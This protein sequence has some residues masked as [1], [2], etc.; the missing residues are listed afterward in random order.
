MSHVDPRPTRPGVW[1]AALLVLLFATPSFA[2]NEVVPL[3][4]IPASPCTT[5]DV[6]LVFTICT[7]NSHF[8]SAARVS[9]V[10]ARVDVATDPTVVCVQCAPDTVGVDFGRL[11]AGHHRLGGM[12]VHH[13]VAGPDSGQLRTENY[14]VD[15]DVRNDCPAPPERLE[16][17]PADSCFDL[18]GNVHWIYG[19]RS[20]RQHRLL[21]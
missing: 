8:L 21:R 6:R 7:C 10:D 16:D 1:V 20:F 2:Q 14:A 18:S 11:S 4:V 3:R 12:I 5:D 13:I 9:A 15:F 17:L 19:Q